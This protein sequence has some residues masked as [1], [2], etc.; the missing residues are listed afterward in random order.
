MKSVS[1]I[2]FPVLLFLFSAGA[3]YSQPSK[4][5]NIA[6]IQATGLPIQDPFLDS[7]DPAMVRPQMEAHLDKLFGPV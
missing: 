4:K 5:A 1:K 2:Y 7:Y 6:L 3:L